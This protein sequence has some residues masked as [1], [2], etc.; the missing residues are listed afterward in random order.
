VPQVESVGFSTIA[1]LLS[2]NRDEDDALDFG[3]LVDPYITNLLSEHPNDY[4]LGEGGLYP[5][6]YC[7][8]VRAADLQ[9]NR[10]SFVEL[11]SDLVEVD[12]EMAN[13]R[14]DAEFYKN[15]WGRYKDGKPE[16]LPSMITY[17]SAPAQLTLRVTDLRERLAEEIKYLVGKYPDDLIMPSN[18]DQIVDP[19]LLIE[20]SPRRVTP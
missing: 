1:G 11:V 4:E 20:V 15:V 8:V 10:K 2:K 14:T 17:K 9:E 18:V 5:M 3:I 19:S 16:F 7:V 13:Y 6:H 12:Q